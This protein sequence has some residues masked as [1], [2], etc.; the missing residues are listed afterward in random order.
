M[1]N[2]QNHTCP[3]CGKPN[4]CA[5]ANC[6]TLKV[7]CWCANAEVSKVAIT[8]IPENLRGK[9]CLCISCASKD[10]VGSAKSV[11]KQTYSNWNSLNCR[12]NVALLLLEDAIENVDMVLASVSHARQEW[13][14]NRQFVG[15]YVILLGA[16]SG[17]LFEWR[18][19]LPV[20]W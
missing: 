17:C 8:K 15:K 9:A 3:L 5:L 18:C 12:K 1:N 6:A 4:D 10:I 16:T 14:L 19:D 13:L 11:I 7:E 2:L 20:I